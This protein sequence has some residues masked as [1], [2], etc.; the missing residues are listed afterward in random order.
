MRSIRRW[1]P[2][3]LLVSPSIILIG[4][5]V[6][7]LIGWNLRVSTRDWRRRG[8]PPA[9]RGL[10]P[11]TTCGRDPVWSLDAPSSA[12]VHRRLHRRHAVRRLDARVPARQG[13]AGRGRLPLDLP[14][15]DGD[16]VHR[17]GDRLALADEPRARRPLHRAQR[18]LRQGRAAASSATSGTW[19]PGL[20]GMAAMA[21]AGDLGAVGLH[22]GALPRRL[23]RRARGAARGRAD[24]RRLGVAR[25]PARRPSPTC[26]R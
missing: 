8:T 24:G 7:G 13:R 16:L 6:Y 4:V 11:T 21:I 22:H 26:D 17:R 10:P 20:G 1:G 2:G 23:A 18:R 5:F 14:L 12:E 15:P 3:L 25:L 19:M 9:T